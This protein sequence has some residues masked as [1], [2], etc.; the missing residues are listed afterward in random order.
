MSREKEQDM[1]LPFDVC[2]DEEPACGAC[3][4][5]GMPQFGPPDVG[6]CSACGG[7]GVA[8]DREPDYDDYDDDMDFDRSEDGGYDAFVRD[9]PGLR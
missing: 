6:R 1:T 9:N 7:S 5:T 3:A 2:E 8:P 4:G